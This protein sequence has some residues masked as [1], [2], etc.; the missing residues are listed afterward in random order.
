MRKITLLLTFLVMVVMTVSAQQ[1]SVSGTV[2]SAD[3]GSTLPGVS[4]VVKGTSYGTITNMD[5]YYTLKLPDGAKTLQFSFVGM[6][7]LEVTISASSVIDVSMEADLLKV[8]EVLVTAIGIS[9]EKKALGYSVQTVDAEAIERSNA[10]D[11]VNALNAKTAGVQIGSSSG[12]AGASTYITIRGAASIGEGNQPL[13]VVDGIP[14]ETGQSWGGS[15]YDTEGAGSSSRSIDLNPNDIENVTVLKGGAATALYGVQAANGVILITTKKGKFD[16]LGNSMK[17]QFN[18]AVT[19]DKL[20]Q[21]QAMQDKFTQGINGN[22]VGGSSTSWGARID[23]MYYIEDETYKWDTLG[24]LTGVSDPNRSDIPAM[25]YDPYEFFQTGV[26]Y[27]NNLNISN[28]ND[29]TTYYFSIGNL[30]QEGIIP[31]N[32]F[33]RTSIRLNAETKL[34]SRLTTGANVSYM[35]TFG[36]FIQQGSNTS[37]VMLGLL[38]TATTFDNA[39][40]YIFDDGTQRNYR[41]GGGYDN[42]YWT[43]NMNHF[44]DEV[45][46]LIGD[47][48]L[49]YKLNDNAAIVYRAG[50]DWYARNYEDYFAVYSRAF[51]S[52]KLEQRHY[53][54]QIFNSDLMLNLNKDF[55]EDLRVRAVIGHNMYQNGLT[56]TSAVANDISII[57]F[58]QISNTTK[59]SATSGTSMYRTAAI[60]GDFQIDYKN[61]FFLGFTGR[62]EWSTTMPESNPDAFYPSINV[63]FIFTEL[64]GMKDNKWLQFGKLRYSWAKT[65]NI[66]GAYYTKSTYDLSNAGDGWTNG[67]DFPFLGYTGYEVGY[68]LGNPD[69]KHETMITN[70]VGIE[71]KFFNNRLGIDFAYFSNNNYDLLLEVPIAASSGYEFAY[72]NAATMESKGVEFML[73][74]SPV[75]TK[76]FTWDI[77]A[78]FTKFSNVVTELAEGVDNV[79]LGGFTDPQIRAVA[80]MEYRSIFGYDWYRDAEGNILINDDPNDSYPDGFPMTDEREM[81]PLGTVNPDWTANILNEFTFKGLTLSALIDIKQGGVMYNG[82][83]FAMNNFGTT[84]ETMYREVTYLADGSIDYANTPAENLYVFNGVLG[85]LNSSDEPVSSGV[86]NTQIVVKDQA[87]FMGQ[88]SNFGGGPTSA[89]IEDASW[90]RLREIT[91]SY[92]LNSKVFEK[93]FIKGLQL[94]FTGRNLLLSTPYSGIDPETSLTGARDSQGMDYFNMPGTKAY[95]FGLRATF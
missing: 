27:D 8:D 40:G 3:D 54:S 53:L 87:W 5:G 90:V 42:P 23:T 45:N 29:V 26:T 14:I 95:T 89:A 32:T 18:S 12:T 52:G 81:V 35:N 61:T 30:R 76:S 67:I 16:K 94:Y 7:N 66:A 63:G 91:L 79:F 28:G 65:A 13:F 10:T 58:E 69:L 75:K 92:Q 50:T 6:K 83:R 62:N 43:A 20:S 2:K 41:N 38:R 84:E 17:V 9:R 4:V 1:R 49:K 44:N 72:M 57:G 56:Y 88:G 39:Q 77:T 31:N 37:G 22:W 74:L 33:N 86:E 25:A 55:T 60:Y 19:F 24:R 70:E 73:N 80:G 71:L 64:P 51:P 34:N 68:L 15:T 59:Q 46:R 47:V 93:T 36:N 82:T 85:H 11:F 21:T 78:N 48:N